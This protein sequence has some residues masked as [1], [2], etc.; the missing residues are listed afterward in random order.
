MLRLLSQ[1]ETVDSSPKHQIKCSALSAE[2]FSKP[3]PV[4]YGAVQSPYGKLP[5]WE[6]G[7]IG[8]RQIV[9]EN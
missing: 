8:I 1:S 7:E 5:G 4:R 2:T 3:A 6:N 9:E